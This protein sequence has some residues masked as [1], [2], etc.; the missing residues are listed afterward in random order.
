MKNT[1]NFNS[2]DFLAFHSESM[3]LASFASGRSSIL[4]S[5]E[6]SSNENM[7]SDVIEDALGNKTKLGFH[8][9]CMILCSLSLSS[10][11]RRQEWSHPQVQP[12]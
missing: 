5:S 2:S 4:H 9:F 8:I 10:Q 7:D 1:H 11:G 12:R 6:P 3:S